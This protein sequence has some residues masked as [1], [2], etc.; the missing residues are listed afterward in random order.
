VNDKEWHFVRSLTTG[1]QRTPEGTITGELP[2]GLAADPNGAAVLTS[3]EG[4]Q[5]PR[6]RPGERLHHLF[7]ECCDRLRRAGQQD[8]AAVSA[9][10]VRWTYDELDE[11]ANQVARYLLARG[12]RAGDRVGLL[13]DDA[14]YSYVGMLAVLKV[15]AAYVPLDGGFPVDRIDFIARDAR[16]RFVLTQERWRAELSGLPASALLLDTDHREIVAYSSRRLA[17]NE[18]PGPVDELCYVIYTSGST[19][20]PKGVAIEQ[21]G[22]CNF[23]RVAAEMYGLRPG[24]RV[25]QGLTIAFDFS[26]EEIWVPWMAGATLVPKPSSASL[27]G[28]DLHEFLVAERV[29]AMCCVPTL[30]TS[31]EQDLP[32]LRFLLVSGEACPQDLVRRWYR[33]GRRLLNVYGP[34][35]ATVTATWTTLHP[36]RPVTL[37]VPL[38]TYTVVI[39]DPDER[40]VL[41]VGEQGE[42]G[43]AGIGLAREYLNRPERTAR[44]FI[45]D[46][47]G[48]TV[49][50]DGRIYRTGDLG[51]INEQG[52]VEYHG[53]IDTQVKIRGYRIELTEIESVLLRMPGIA[54]AVVDTHD[55]GSGMPE[56]VAYYSVRRDAGELTPGDIAGHLRDR[57]PGYMVPAYLER[58]DA[59]PLLPSD[60][61]DRKNLPAPTGRRQVSL[62]DVIAPRT[63]FEEKVVEALAP[64]LGVGPETISADSHL[65][66]DLGTNSLLLAKFRAELRRDPELPPVSMREV[67][68]HPTVEELAGLLKTLRVPASPE[69]AEAVASPAG[70]VSTTRYV[71]CGAGQL[72][73]AA[74][75]LFLLTLLFTPGFDW[76]STATGLGDTYL[77]SLVVGM[78]FFAVMC[79]A[80]IALK[81]LLVGRWKSTEIP[82]WGP[83]YLRFWCVKTL[84]RSNPLMAFVG[85]PLY[86]LYLRALGAR[87]GR[88]VVVLT[89]HIPICTDLLTV[90]ADS[91]IRKDVYVNCYRAEA[92]RI[93]TGPVV[94]GER[95]VI[96]EGSVIDI[97]ASVGDDGQLGHSSALHRGRAIPAG[98]HWHGS[99]CEPT[100]V[101][102]LGIPPARISRARKVMH[103]VTRLL[104]L[105]AVYF[106]LGTGVLDDSVL[107]G[108]RTFETALPSQWAFYGTALEV[109]ALLFFGAVLAGLLLVL[110]VPRL[111]RVLLR[112][113]RVYPLY[114][115]RY[116]AL[117]LIHQLTN[118]A[119]FIHLFGDSAYIVHYLRALGYRLS[120]IQQTGSNFGTQQQHEV[121]YLTSVGTGTMVSD[122]LSA[123]NTRYSSTSFLVDEVDIGER[124]FLGNSVRYPAGGRTGANCLLATKVMVPLDGE[125]RE[126]TGLLG[127]PAFPIPRTVQRDAD[128]DRPADGAETRRAIARKTRHNTATMVLFLLACAVYVFG[129]VTLGTLDDYLPTPP[130]VT[131][132]ATEMAG[133]LLSIGYFALL[134]RASLGFRRLRPRTCSIY[135]R[136]FWR[137]ERFW[138]FMT[139]FL[140][141]LD[142]TPLKGPFLRLLGVRIGRQVFDDGATIVEKSLT[143]I[144]DG[145]ALNAGSVVQAHSL[146]DGAFKSDHIVVESGVTLGVGA[147]VHYGVVIREGASLDADSFLMKGEEVGSRRHWRG[148]PA[149]EAEVDSVAGNLVGVRG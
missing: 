33:P 90:G 57:L 108:R 16:I 17:D 60:K 88:G 19:G 138:K 77:R 140:A 7:E 6:W 73:A 5:A 76:I 10:S 2:A 126:N 148:N 120:P 147:F 97:G 134:E 75:Y 94:L 96:G 129:V 103:T 70:R 20:T 112:P 86:T 56:L 50:P 68:E 45:P 122:G 34:T 41:P 102:Y 52:E 54:Q 101:D 59:I 133:I 14:F 27:V 28:S 72:L 84:V 142:G 18:R 26:V 24:D 29:T 106:P 30:L 44:S 85:S 61:A 105:L 78:G 21:A 137:H 63:V 107:E 39:L 99:P 8:R 136:A 113:G 100:T 95:V 149:Q 1:T 25:Y 128:I 119:F 40:R 62:E 141:V 3:P 42:I 51:T 135:D 53:R 48:L 36:D 87:L 104:P 4:V 111:L 64:V 146:E 11:R 35:E 93:H 22:I 98:T 127:A 43:I 131:A 80:P 15:N 109:S 65:F 13:F 132:T 71:L 143:T 37:G 46:F 144:G 89:K 110:T 74:T 116:A 81:W 83:G 117:R 31:L 139:P 69:P 32:D 49:D 47:A 58:L 114:G 125:V 124:S 38:P 12:V 115:M 91:V 55:P 82:L 118:A 121:P 130:A 67:Y 66:H 9:G 92:G 79:T 145:C 23:V 123:I